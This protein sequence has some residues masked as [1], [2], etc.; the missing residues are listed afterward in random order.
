[1]GDIDLTADFIAAYDAWI[2]SMG[3]DDEI[4]SML[5][6]DDMTKA[7]TALAESNQGK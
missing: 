4:A 6:Y 5:L 7:H 2:A 1:M 3:D